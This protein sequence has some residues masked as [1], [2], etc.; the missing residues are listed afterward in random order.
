[1]KP[2]P[3]SA[4][5]LA[6]SPER[7]RERELWHYDKPSGRS[8][9]PSTLPRGRPLGS[10][11]KIPQSIEGLRVGDIV[12]TPRGMH[13]KVLKIRVDGRI[14]AQYLAV[15]WTQGYLTILNPKMCSKVIT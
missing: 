6:Y 8:S 1:M 2:K 13:A 14:D 11:K 15:H 12:K 10:G 3:T 9:K 5:P 7:R 4:A